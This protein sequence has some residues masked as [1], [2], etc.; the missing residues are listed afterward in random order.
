M[1]LAV[2]DRLNRP[3][4][5]L[6]VSVTDRCNFRCPYCMPAE[7]FGHDYVFM[8]KE[9]I[10]DFEEILRVVALLV[11]LGVRKLRLTG[12]EPLLRKGL[13]ELIRGVREIPE[14]ED[15]AMT[16]NGTLLKRTA[17]QLRREGLSRLTISLDSL[18]PDVFSIMNG[19]RLSLEDVL[20]GIEAAE[21][22]GFT[23]IK[24]N[25]VVQKGVND[26]VIMD[27]AQHFRGTGHI[28]RFIEYMDV[29]NR[30][31]WKL[32]EV[33]TAR[34]ILDRIDGSIPLEPVESNYVG[35]V[36]RR[37]RYQDGSGEIGVI[38]SVSQ[39]FCGDCSRARLTTDGRLVTCLFA[40]GGTDLRALLRDGTS[41]EELSARIREIWQGRTDRYSEERA[42]GQGSDVDP[43]SSSSARR[44]EMYEVGG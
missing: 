18:D 23:G 21:Q 13:H 9:Q 26:H 31:G 41:D 30:N 27:L 20:E 14:I 3:L 33:L 4:R 17:G 24:I 37:Y 36:A 29:G 42:N 40:Q 15:I 19:G 44:V 32:D 8:P 10:L 38:T 34:E 1:S 43:D 35:E 11:P 22:A 12:G 16:T 28:V 5:D 25:C 7:K 2:H 39:P 6:R